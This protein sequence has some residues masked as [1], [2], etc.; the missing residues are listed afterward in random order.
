M[1][2]SIRSRFF[3]VAGAVAILPSLYMAADI[4]TL[5][6][7]R[8]A[9]EG[10]ARS[11]QARSA[12]LSGTLHL[13]GERSLTQVAIS[14]DQP[15]SAA[16]RAAID[17][18]RA[19]NAAE[20][21][22]LGRLLL[23]LPENSST[24]R[25]SRDISA[26]N[27][28]LA[29]IRREADALMR[30]PL[31]ERPAE[32]VAQLPRQLMDDVAAFTRSRV[33]LRAEA[34]STSTTLTNLEAVQERGWEAR[35]YFGR[36]RTR[37]AIALARG[38]E[39]IAAR[40]LSEMQH[41]SG[42]GDNALQVA[43]LSASLPNMPA[44]L[45]ARVQEASQAVNGPYGDLR[46][47]LLALA[48]QPRPQYP[49]TF[50]AFFSRS[51]DALNA[52][53]SVVREGSVATAAYWQGRITAA[54][55][56]IAVASGMMLFCM[57]CGLALILF[58]MR[59]LLGPF[60]AIRRTMTSLAEGKRGMVIPYLESKNEAG[61]M[62]QAVAIFARGMEEREA[63]EARAREVQ[64][65]AL[66]EQRQAR[67][68][69]ADTFEKQIG[70]VSRTLAAQA[71]ALT[72]AAHGLDQ[73]ISNNRS[74]SQ[75]ALGDAALASE[76][77]QDVA[78]AAEALTLSVAEITRQVAE[79]SK[80]SLQAAAR[81]ASSDATMNELAEGARRIGDVVQMI[82]DIAGQTNLLSLNAT[83]EA[84]RAGEAGKGF[85][86]VA[87]EVK[88]LAGQTA[89]AT[90][91]ISRQIGSMQSATAGAVTAIREISL[92][93]AEMQQIAQAISLAVEEQ[94]TNTGA[95]AESAIR[96]SQATTRLRGSA[97]EVASGAERSTAA[98]NGLSEAST[99]IAAEDQA[100]RREL[101]TLVGNLRAA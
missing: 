79:A 70:G 43:V 48:D 90:E 20:F 34:A 64:E 26:L 47:S 72:R 29:E 83:I 21:A 66:Q 80:T 32:R 97:D 100:L 17:A 27:G 49:V 78:S 11:D 60:D 10:Y 69:L 40:V 67:L 76:G 55:R 7:D 56:R 16:L 28:R 71:E 85:A 12:L 33:L 3:V 15:V 99:A 42:R 4:V 39:R 59:G 86:V 51:A 31:A 61:Q 6:K 68:A 9:L 94:N 1:L 95:I 75:T 8:T 37:F 62:A 14:L 101:Q 77:V 23:T 53:E 73:E 93:V 18:Q 96:A 58:A 22:T 89:K 24:Q 50:E 84:A 63:L 92:V 45:V 57:L 36:E 25:F 19:K 35:E 87:S 52:L 2:N 13:S 91:E 98:L 30:V 65:Q 46:R 81:A 41:Y 88:N 44:S 54:G 38:N 5:W 74:L 82:A